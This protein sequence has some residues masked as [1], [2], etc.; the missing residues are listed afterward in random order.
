MIGIKDIVLHASEL[1]L[2][3]KV[4][5]TENVQNASQQVEYLYYGGE[6]QHFTGTLLC[7]LIDKERLLII[8]SH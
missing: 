8:V 4:H 2:A 5:E 6:V 3:E 1:V 7:G